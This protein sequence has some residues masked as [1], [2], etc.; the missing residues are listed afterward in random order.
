MNWRWQI[1]TELTVCSHQLHCQYYIGAF[2]LSVISHA[3]SRREWISWQTWA[4]V[5]YPFHSLHTTRAPPGASHHYKISWSVIIVGSD[6]LWNEVMVFLI[7]Q[8]RDNR[9]SQRKSALRQAIH[10]HNVMLLNTC[11]Q[12]WESLPLSYYGGILDSSLTMYSF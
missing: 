9:R 7:Y 1:T 12:M 2:T 5:G 8:S 11:R 4:N 6:P 10:T 3:G